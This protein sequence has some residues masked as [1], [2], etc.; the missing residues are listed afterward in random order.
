[1]IV[2]VR[3][4]KRM[5]TKDR[6]EN[7]KGFSLVELLI[8]IAIIAILSAAIAPMLIRY[9][10]KARKQKDVAAAET[11]YH[12]A[13]VTLATSD[14]SIL[15]AWENRSGNALYD[16][17]ANGEKYKG[18]FLAWARGLFIYHDENYEFK[19]AWNNAQAQWDFVEEFNPYINQ[20]EKASTFNKSNKGNAVHFSY[21][22]TKDPK[23]RYKQYAD[24]WMIFR[25]QD[26]HT[27]EVWIGYKPDGKI[28]MPYYR[29]YPDT[30]KRWL[31]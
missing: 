9:I 15:G 3:E 7:N 21:K 31:K 5:T 10:D 16:L 12:A 18:E 23:K 4:G 28:V 26:T 29:I 2:D 20:H 11:I 24:C 25:R 27:V 30:D 6:K 22:K 17:E 19:N 1:M 14:S 13:D 8:V